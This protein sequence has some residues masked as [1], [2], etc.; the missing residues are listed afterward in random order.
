MIC[1][2]FATVLSGQSHEVIGMIF[3]CL[4]ESA[5]YQVKR[6]S[7]KIF[8]L[9]RTPEWGRKAWNKMKNSIPI[10]VSQKKYLQAL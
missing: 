10:S 6:R 2:N 8:K 5:D 9:R 7:R 4:L 1:A 3:A